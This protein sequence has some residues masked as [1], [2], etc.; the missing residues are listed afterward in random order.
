MYISE[1]AILNTV[2]LDNGRV[3][4][5]GELNKRSWPAITIDILEAAVNPVNKMRI[6]YR[7]NLNFEQFNR[8]FSDL[9]IKGFIEEINGL[10][11]RV[12]YRT[13]ERGR[14]LLA[15]LGKAQELVAAPG[16]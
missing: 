5:R 12:M 7:A 6:M 3:W 15:I 9:L 4:E 14:E 1:K 10:N 16:R 11:G 2:R 8:Y 13:T